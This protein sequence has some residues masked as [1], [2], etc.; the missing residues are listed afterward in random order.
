[1]ADRVDIGL[2]TLPIRSSQYQRLE[3]LVLD[4][5]RIG[6]RE[7]VMYAHAVRPGN[8]QQTNQ[9][10]GSHGSEEGQ[11]DMAKLLKFI[12]KFNRSRQ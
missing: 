1:M 3:Q 11:I 8:S 12:R 6:R 2:P 7:L 5:D 9:T 4:R 10:E